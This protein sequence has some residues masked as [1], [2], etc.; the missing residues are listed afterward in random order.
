MDTA[1]VIIASLVGVLVLYRLISVSSRSFWRKRIK[2]KGRKISWSKAIERVRRREGYFI[3][4]VSG[5]HRELFYAAGNIPNDTQSVF[6]A[7]HWLAALV[8]CYPG[9]ISVTELRT[10]GAGDLCVEV[11]VEALQV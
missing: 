7:C 10:Y 11:N 2:E 4:G 1:I 6:D 9:R 8:E 5:S 3:I